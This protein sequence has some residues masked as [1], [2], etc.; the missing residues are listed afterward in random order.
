MQYGSRPL[1]FRSHRSRSNPYWILVLLLLVVGSA[2][3]LQALQ[4]EEIRSPFLPTP[5]PTRTANSYALEGQ[6]HFAAGNLNKAIDAYKEAAR[7]D[8][9]DPMLLVEQARIQTYSSAMLT[10]DSEKRD[11]LLEALEAIN[12][13]RDLA[14][15]DSTVRAVRAFVLDW[16]ASPSLVGD[17]YTKYLVEA[18]QEAVRALQ[19]DNQNTL[20]LVYYAEILIDQLKLTQAQ[21]FIGQALQRND[22]SMDLH[23]VNA[24][25]LENYGDYAGAIE[26]Y[27]RAAA[28]TPN[29]TSLYISIGVNYRQIKRYDDAL[30]YF[31]KAV[32][33]NE[34]LGIRD[35]IPYL[36]IGKTY[37]QTGDFFAA[38]LNVRKALLYN[39]TN[40]DVYGS[41][42]VIYFKARNYET[43]I[44]ALKCTVRVCS[45][46]ESCTVRNRG[47][48]CDEAENAE[49]AAIEGLPLTSSTV[50]YY[51]T[52]ASALA[53]MHRPYNDYCQEAMQVMS[54]VRRGFSQDT[55]ILSI[56]EP[57]EQICESFGYSRLN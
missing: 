10:T 36:A 2:F 5:Y 41:L 51:F 20:A 33:I 49:S 39:P 37:S 13:A 9:T 30:E 7:L 26:E 19:L 40:A 35:P 42:G 18:E 17:E 21:Q 23:R 57:S 45:A 54:E 3:V 53:G 14:P 22:E 8:P 25:I 6:T 52:Y 28:I 44:L 29:L 16:L 27:K 46:E 32:T 34:Q 4:K 1:S 15:E 47:E 48:A 24:F 43:A 56:I 11:R 12:G 38:G 50:V 55:T 31:T